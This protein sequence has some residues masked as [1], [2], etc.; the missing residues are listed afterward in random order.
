[1]FSKC[2]LKTLLLVAVLLPAALLIIVGL[3]RLLFVLGDAPVG[4]F[5]E[6]AAIGGG[7]IWVLDLLALLLAVAAKHASERDDG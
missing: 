5:F 1:M 7:L 3:S 4:L 2:V 6:R